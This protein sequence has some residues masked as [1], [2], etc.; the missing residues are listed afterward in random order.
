MKAL[1]GSMRIS[2]DRF[3][4]V[5]PIEEEADMASIYDRVYRFL[6]LAL[7]LGFGLFRVYPFG[8]LERWRWGQSRSRVGGG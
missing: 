8:F 4:A 2:R 7:G 5:R 3:E 1:K 6:A